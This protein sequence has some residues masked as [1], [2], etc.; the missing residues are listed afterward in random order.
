[1]SHRALYYPWTC[2]QDP[3]FLFETLLYWDRW[4]CVVPIEHYL[5]NTYGPAGP[6]FV[7]VL[8]EAHERFATGIEPTDE[9]KEIVHA[10][11]AALL[12]VPAP[13]WCR[14][15]ALPSDGTPIFI[16]K[17]HYK[18]VSL[19]RDHG[20]ANTEATAESGDHIVLMRAVACVVMSELVN[21]VGGES[22][23]TI[24]EDPSTFRGSCNALLW[25]VGAQRALDSGQ[26]EAAEVPED[27]DSAFLVASF[28][29]LAHD[30]TPV[31]P[32]ELRRLI[33]LREDAGFNELREQF[34]S[35]V[36]QF[37]AEL[38]SAS[39]LAER[40]MIHDE[41]KQALSMDRDALVKDLRAAR[42][43]AV[44]EKDGLIATVAGVA[45]GGG[46]LAALGPAGVVIGVGLASVGLAKQ[47][48]ER[49]REAMDNNWSS[50]LFAAENPSL[51]LL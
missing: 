16:S 3:R 22:L 50:W 6:D 23:P 31:T 43:G 47:Y 29:R 45:V 40:G 4:A 25:R 38:Q 14:P 34:C 10:R 27:N 20:W 17:L 26:G 30:D 41:W 21:A 2:I 28:L 51:K 33:T 12:D 44:T 5:P 9:I 19:L 13:D 8:G 15:E 18:T 24:T 7:D 37:V 36:D 11:V 39:S 32:D 35:K 48:R 1:V 46:A 49:R 42:I